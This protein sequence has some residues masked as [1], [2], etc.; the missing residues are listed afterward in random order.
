VPPHHG[1][2]PQAQPGAIGRDTRPD[3]QRRPDAHGRAPGAHEGDSR[4][5]LDEIENPSMGLALRRMWRRMGL[6]R[7][8]IRRQAR[9]PQFVI[10]KTLEH[11]RQRAQISASPFGRL[12]TGSRR[13][14]T[15]RFGSGR[16]RAP[17]QCLPGLAAGAVFDYSMSGSI[18]LPPRA[19]AI[20]EDAWLRNIQSSKPACGASSPYR[21]R[22]ACTL[23]L[24][25]AFGASRPATSAA[26]RLLSLRRSGLLRRAMQ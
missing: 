19:A 18:W 8:R 17:I 23:A 6:V 15:A 9:R 22:P 12:L 7:R 20:R 11:L 25:P 2:A 10:R 16:H 5:A 13:R 21:D 4:T 3:C 26:G 24:H 14:S 1:S